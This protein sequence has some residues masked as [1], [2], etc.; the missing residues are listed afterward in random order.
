VPFEEQLRAASSGYW[1]RFIQARWEV[2]TETMA[3]LCRFLDQDPDNTRVR[4]ALASLAAAQGQLESGITAELCVDFLDAW[5]EDLS[6][7]QRF[8]TTVNN[9]GSTREA[10]DLLHLKTWTRADFGAV[11]VEGERAPV[12]PSLQ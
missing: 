1:A 7:W 9:V 10:M 5:Q 11:V 6:D 2:L 3:L 12:W 8:S 4:A